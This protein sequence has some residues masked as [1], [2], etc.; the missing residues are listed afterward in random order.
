MMWVHNLAKAAFSFNF[1]SWINVIIRKAQKRFKSAEIRFTRNAI[2][3]SRIV[4]LFVFFFSFHS[5]QFVV[6]QFWANMMMSK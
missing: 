6:G 5:M 2:F 3:S 4:H 1:K